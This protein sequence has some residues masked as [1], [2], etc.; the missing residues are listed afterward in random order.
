MHFRKAF[1][2]E[3]SDDAECPPSIEITVEA[4]NLADFSEAQLSD[5]LHLLLVIRNWYRETRYP[6][7]DS[8]LHAVD[9]FKNAIKPQ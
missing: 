9:A 2:P 5:H 4:V 7:P 1:F 8:L 3:A 6:A